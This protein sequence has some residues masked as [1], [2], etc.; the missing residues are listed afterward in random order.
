MFFV[1]TL[2]AGPPQ[3][4]LGKVR[5][6]NIGWELGTRPTAARPSPTPTDPPIADLTHERIKRRPVLYG[7]I[8]E[9]ERAAGHR[10]SPWVTDLSKSPTRSPS[11]LRF[12]L[13][14]PSTG[15]NSVGAPR[16]KMITGRN[17]V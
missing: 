4:T 17:F 1:L 9:Y 13:G 6:P 3:V 15:D 10:F 16:P 14:R 11:Q 12:P 2:C 5:R 7:L 8:N